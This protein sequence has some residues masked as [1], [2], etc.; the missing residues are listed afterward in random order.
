MLDCKKKLQRKLV[1]IFLDRNTNLNELCVHLLVML[2]YFF[3]VTLLSFRETGLETRSGNPGRAC[4]IV[5]GSDVM[6]NLILN[7]EPVYLL[8]AIVPADAAV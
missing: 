2:I 8:D 5:Q 1:L 7:V 4:Y 6:C 3:Y